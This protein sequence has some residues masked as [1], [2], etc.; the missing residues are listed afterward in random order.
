M[1]LS[2][3]WK[4][5]NDM[6]MSGEHTTEK[7]FEEEPHNSGSLSCTSTSTLED[8]SRSYSFDQ[9][10]EGFGE[11]IWANGQPRFY[12]HYGWDQC[13]EQATSCLCS[14]RSAFT[15][16]ASSSSA[17]PSFPTTKPVSELLSEIM[18]VTS[19]LVD[20]SVNESDRLS[21]DEPSKLQDKPNGQ[22]EECC[23]YTSSN[24]ESWGRCSSL[25]GSDEESSAECRTTDKSHELTGIDSLMISGRV[26]AK[27]LVNANGNG[28]LELFS[29]GCRTMRDCMCHAFKTRL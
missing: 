27:L 21:S 15:D 11:S 13:S 24:R 23:S 12:V 8:E 16:A 14:L 17:P 22:S 9:I 7:S 19:I 6:G 4:A 25:G 5:T 29:A 18:P 28:S 20:S 26:M 2:S 1:N 10:M 3:A